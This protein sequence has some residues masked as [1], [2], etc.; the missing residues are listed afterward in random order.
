MSDKGKRSRRSFSEEFKRQ[1][2]AEAMEPGASA[3]A[4][5]R[6]HDLNANLLFTWKRR[7]GMSDRFLPIE[8]SEA[9]PA[10][11]PVSDE[12]AERSGSEFTSIE[13]ALANGNRI[14]VKGNLDA[15]TMCRLVQSLA[16]P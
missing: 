12:P 8:I 3:A 14:S 16:G 1:V 4:V 6:R 13:I 10:V 9:E 2:V 5:A 15:D 11:P 7:Y